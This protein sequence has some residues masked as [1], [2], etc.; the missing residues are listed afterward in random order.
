[1]AVFWV[2]SFTAQEIDR[3]LAFEV[4]DGENVMGR[5]ARAWAAWRQR[6]HQE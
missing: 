6:L 2:V 5:N 1:M 4:G 3:L